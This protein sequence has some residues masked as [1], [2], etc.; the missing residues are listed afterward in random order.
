MLIKQ[1]LSLRHRQPN[2]L[3]LS[4]ATSTTTAARE[5]LQ[6]FHGSA[7]TELIRVG[8]GTAT[9]IEFSVRF[10]GVALID[11]LV[12]EVAVVLLQM[13]LGFVEVGGGAAVVAL[14]VAGQVGE[15]RAAGAVVAAVLLVAVG[16]V[17]VRHDEFL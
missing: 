16:V 9:S 4:T 5:L 15:V 2:Q 17:A 12:R 11:V 8:R 1:L 13:R 14:G 6:R 7:S 3:V 10:D